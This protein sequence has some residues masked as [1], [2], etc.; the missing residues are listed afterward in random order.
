[1]NQLQ[2][3]DLQVS[4]DVCLPLSHTDRGYERTASSAIEAFVKEFPLEEDPWLPADYHQ[5]SVGIAKELEGT[6]NQTLEQTDA[7]AQPILTAFDFPQMVTGQCPAVGHTAL[8]FM[9]SSRGENSASEQLSVVDTQ[10]VVVN[11]GAGVPGSPVEIGAGQESSE[12]ISREGDEFLVGRSEGVDSTP[13]PNMSAVAGSKRRPKI[14]FVKKH[15]V[16]DQ[17]DVEK[18]DGSIPED[19]TCGSN[20]K[21]WWKCEKGHSWIASVYNRCNLK[22]PTGCPECMG[23]SS[24]REL[25]KGHAVAAQWDVAKNGSI[26]ED[27]TCGSN[28]KFWWKCE[29]GHSWIAP[30]YNRCNLKKPTGC[31]VCVRESSGLRFVKDH[32]AAD[33]WDVEKN[34][35]SIPEDL[36]CGSNRK[37]WWKCENGHG[38]QATV[39]RRC[40]LK[41]PSGCPVCPGRSSGLRFVKDHSAA[42]KWDEVKNEGPIPEGLTCGSAQ[43]FWWKCERQHNW[44]TNVYSICSLKNPSGCPTCAGRS[45]VRRFVKDHPAADQWD[46]VKNEGPIPEDLTCG[47]HRRFWWKCKDGQSKL[48][49]VFSRCCTPITKTSGRSKSFKAKAKKRPRTED[50]RVKQPSQKKRRG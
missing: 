19:L 49:P 5:I 9:E 4:R 29:K 45:S 34:S 47:S 10:P 40:C 41:K 16:A 27:L 30:V 22:K 32:P 37:F 50:S 39:D 36:T 3:Q 18:N 35:G 2:G 8:D 17:W 44:K 26:P 13:N 11:C 43:K 1:M 15:Q 31:S 28:R 38:W 7:V 42:A 46:E 24:H 25:V 23:K 20:R 21:F 14:R 12:E 6:A 33:Q 48:R